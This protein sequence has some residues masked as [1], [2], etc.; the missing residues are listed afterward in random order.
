[1]KASN[2]KN[3]QTSTKKMQQGNFGSEENGIEVVKGYKCHLCY[4]PGHYALKY[5]NK[6]N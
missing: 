5:S 2:K 6:D 4:K 1:L 3:S